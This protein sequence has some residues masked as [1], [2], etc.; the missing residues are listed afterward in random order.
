MEGEIREQFTEISARQWD[1]LLQEDLT[2]R[3]AVAFLQS[4]LKLRTFAGNL[5]R[6]YPGD[7]LEARLIRGLYSCAQEAGE[8]VREDSVRKKVQNWMMNKNTPSDREE[9]F[10]IAFALGLDE[11][12]T[13]TLLLQT[14][15]QGI[16]YRNGREMIFAFSL[17][18]HQSYKTACEN[19]KIFAGRLGETQPGREI[20]TQ[21]VRMKFENLPPG[22]DVIEFLLRQSESLGTYHN[23]AYQYFRKMLDLLVGTDTQEEAYSL[24][25][26]AEHY[27]RMNM[28]QNRK[29]ASYSNMQKVIKKYWPGSRNIK[30]M[31]NRSEDVSRKVLLLLY[32]I[33]GGVWDTEYDELDE[34]YISAGE[35]LE[36]HC[37]RLNKIMK[38]CGMS[39][40]DPRNPFDYLVLYCL[41]PQE[42]DDMSRRME[43]VVQEL[44]ADSGEKE[45]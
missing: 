8:N 31:Q 30:A 43:Q 45:K 16:H 18:N 21:I 40:M 38:E 34:D 4:G 42:D 22:E 2:P 6:L 29:M 7:D 3:Q 13:D 44:F 5:R 1:Y 15:E 41:K 27:L 11:R 20:R 19:A 28:P 24:E 33:T 23:T 17:R 32:I 35:A 37:R 39:L 10:R 26:V 14:V 25:Y 12:Q 36:E 9:I